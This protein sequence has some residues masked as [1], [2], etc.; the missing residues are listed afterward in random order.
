M[1]RRLKYGTYFIKRIRSRAKLFIHFSTHFCRVKL[2]FL[3]A[4]LRPVEQLDKEVELGCISSGRVIDQLKGFT[5][6][7]NL[8][9]LSMA[10]AL[11][12]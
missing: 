5:S 4:L 1:A 8:N 2:D 9:R 12:K 7:L 3:E 6:S 10:I 11:Q